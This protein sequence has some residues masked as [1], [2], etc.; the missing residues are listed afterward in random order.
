MA[1]TSDEGADETDRFVFSIGVGQRL[2]PIGPPHFL[3]GAGRLQH[4]ALLLQRQ[5]PLTEAFERHPDDPG[6]E[7][8]AGGFFAKA[9]ELVVSDQCE[10][11]SVRWGTPDFRLRRADATRRV[12]RRGCA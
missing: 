2:P 6:L 9:V 5:A 10:P 8:R 12:R 7:R 1:E 11:V 3:R 4:R